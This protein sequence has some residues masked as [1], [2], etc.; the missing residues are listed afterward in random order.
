MKIKSFTL[1]IIIFVLIFGGIFV[2]SALNLWKTESSKIP[3]R[4]TTGV[5]KGEYNPEDIRGSYS[6]YDISSSFDIPL[7]DLQKA[8]VLPNDMDVANFQCK[9]LEELYAYLTDEGKEIGTGSVK[10]FVALY[11]GLPIELIADNYLPEQA[12]SVILA[13]NLNLTHQ[14]Q[15]YLESHSI[16]ITTSNIDSSSLFEENAENDYESE[17]K[18]KG[19]TSFKE[20]LDWGIQEE[21]IKMLINDDIPNPTMSIRDYCIQNG[22]SFS[23]VKEELQ[24]ELDK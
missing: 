11:K 21:S 14:Q 4:Y 19:Q 2:S 16:Y 12:I 6:F 23:T 24:K 20:V 18:I 9:S 13:E 15:N 1:S 8:F 7:E 22:I 17:K 10:I 5:F 3:A